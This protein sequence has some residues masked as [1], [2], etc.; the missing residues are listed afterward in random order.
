MFFFFVPANHHTN[1]ILWSNRY[2]N[3]RERKYIWSVH[4]NLFERWNN[5]SDWQRITWVWRGSVF[6]LLSS[7]SSLFLINAMLTA[8]NRF[9]Y[10]W[11]ES[12]RILYHFVL[13]SSSLAHHFS[14]LVKNMIFFT[15]IFVVS[16]ECC[17]LFN[18]REQV[19]LC[20][21]RVSIFCII[22]FTPPHQ[23]HVNTREQTCLCAERQTY[24]GMYQA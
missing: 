7:R 9:V 24:G 22:S 17:L 3:L 5:P 4:A 19:C 13:Y 14:L 21:D 2:W 10:A 16:Q 1:L 12:K 23:Y 8:G 18:D 20:V 6:C 15:H 11:E